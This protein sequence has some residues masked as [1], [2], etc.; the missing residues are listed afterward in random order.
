M[1]HAFARESRLASG[2]SAAAIIN[3]ACTARFQSIEGRS[4]FNVS[5]VVVD[6][7]RGLAARGS[8]LLNSTSPS[9]RLTLT[10]SQWP[11]AIPRR[12]IWEQHS[13]REVRPEP[14]RKVEEAAES[15]FKAT[16]Q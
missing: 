15:K 5:I 6:A 8:S 11:P 4:F 14:E 2:L 10:Y 13:D 16:A 12:R 9:S 7:D 1:S 3:R